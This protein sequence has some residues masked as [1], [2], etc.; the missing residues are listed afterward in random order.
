M[1]PHRFVDPSDPTKIYLTQPYTED[2]RLPEAPTYAKV[3]DSDGHKYE[4][5]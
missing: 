5:M 1:R 2:Q 4:P 3:L